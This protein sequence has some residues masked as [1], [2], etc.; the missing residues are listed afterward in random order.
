VEFA[1]ANIDLK[2]VEAHG[3]VRDI[4]RAEGVDELVGSITRFTS[5][6]QLLDTNEPNVDH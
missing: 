3:P 5:L 4:L 6:A 1:A 2:I